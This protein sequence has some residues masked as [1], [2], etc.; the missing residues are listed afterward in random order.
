VFTPPNAPDVGTVLLEKISDIISSAIQYPFEILGAGSNFYVV[1]M[2]IL[3]YVIFCWF[4]PWLMGKTETLY[5]KNG[6]TFDANQARR[7][8]RAGGT[9]RYDVNLGA[10][11]SFKSALE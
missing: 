5:L 1:G 10:K 7:I 4:L 11:E 6:N 8:G 9:D 3:G 2:F